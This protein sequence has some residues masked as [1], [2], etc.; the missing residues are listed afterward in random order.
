MEFKKNNKV[1]E[2]L[3]FEKPITSESANFF[4]TSLDEIKEAKEF[5]PS[6]FLR[7]DLPLP[8]L[9]EPEV[10]RHYTNLSR[11]NF[12]IDANFYPLGSCTMKY[13]PK[14]NEDIAQ[15]EEFIFLHPY[16][17]E[18]YVQGALQIMYELNKILCEITGMRQFS[19]QAS[20]GAHGELIGMLIIKAFHAL[21]NDKRSKVIIPDSAH[22]TNPASAS[23]CGFETV[24]VRSTK[25]GLVDIDELNKKTDDEVA[26]MMLTN[27][28]TLGLFE[29]QILDISNILHKKGA[30][31]YYDGANFN[32]L[33]GIVK[34]SCMGFDVIHLNLHKTFSTPHGS[35][36]PGAAAVGVV[37][38]LVEFLPVPIVGKE[39]DR[40]YFNYNLN[41]TIGRVKAFYGNF[42][43][44]LKS[45]AYLLRIG[46]EGIK[47]VAYNSV[48]N[49]N[50]I[51]EKL[52]EYY[53]PASIRQCMHEV[54]FSCSKQKNK[55]I[56]A[57]DI[58]KR[59]IDFGIHPPTM[60]FPLIVKEA[61]MV[62]PTE[63]ESKDTLDRFI[64]IMIA[65]DEEIENHPERL[66]NA[67][68]TAP[69][70]RVNEVKAARF[71]NLRW[72]KP[73]E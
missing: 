12:S 71:P 65:I 24:V 48:L 16:Q 19:F 60:Y 64:N 57:L 61:L 54:V 52:K 34:P 41:H 44:I 17:E 22:G 62:E 14:V 11:L 32:A 28:N 40:F 67:P 30:L 8:S 23:M 53:T 42:S 72:E 2:E 56:T 27:P 47:R 39:K 10:V 33:M 7:K 55:G 20:A 43:V 18:K 3:I 66:K 29:E 51:K 13:N 58:A 37:N 63:T 4:S 35:G 36:G 26:A 69:V 68:L 49:A 38:K 1:R 25:E 31:L 73:G 46:R 45:Y 5:I 9:G 59:L 70:R 15:K 21:N 50:Y 6:K